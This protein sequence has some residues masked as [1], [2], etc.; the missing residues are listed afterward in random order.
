MPK[1]DSGL[2]SN[3]LLLRVTKLM[4]R[5]PGWNQHHHI[6]RKFGNRLRRF[7]GVLDD[8]EVRLTHK[9]IDDSREQ[10]MELH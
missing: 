5:G 2:C 1:P 4:R 7:G 8:D 9:A 3:P 10:D 6:T